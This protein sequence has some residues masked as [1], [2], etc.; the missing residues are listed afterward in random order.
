MTKD[1]GRA[2]DPRHETSQ[3]FSGG[4]RKTERVLPFCAKAH[5]IIR[6]TPIR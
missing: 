5:V 4:E 1:G 3:K 2:D 6:D